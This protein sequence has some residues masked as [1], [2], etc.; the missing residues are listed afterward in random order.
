MCVADFSG[1]VNLESTNLVNKRMCE[2]MMGLRLRVMAYSSIFIQFFLSLSYVF[3]LKICVRL[4]SGSIGTGI[5]ELSV[6]MDD[7]LWCDR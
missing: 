3:S 7:E 1:T 5:L 6:H 4:F 2:C